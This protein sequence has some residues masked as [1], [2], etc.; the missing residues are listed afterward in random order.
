MA[1]TVKDLHDFRRARSKEMLRAFWALLSG[2]SHRLIAWDDVSS[3][4]RLRGGISRGV[5]SIAISQIVGSVGRYQDFDDAFLPARSNLSE[6]WMRLN[7]AFDESKNLPPIQLYKVGDLYFVLDG[8]HRVSVARQHGIDFIDAEVIEVQSRI[9]ITNHDLNS[10]TL[11]I[12]GEYSDFLERTQLDRLRPE[13]NVRFSIGGGY[14]RLT[15]HI[16]KHRYFMGLDLKRD[17]SEDEAVTDWYDHVYLPI[18]VAIREANVLP[19]FPNRTEADLY[20][21]MSE[22][23]YYLHEESGADVSPQVAIADMMKYLNEKEARETDALVALA[24]TQDVSTNLI[25]GRM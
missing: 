14:T 22:H 16:A 8:N 2:K 11:E 3:K 20:L 7:R 5:Q 13:Q 4:L 21:W 18:I 12:L 1:T 9:P 10:D 23:Q 17:I 19:H 24:Q 25:I 6:R 15:E